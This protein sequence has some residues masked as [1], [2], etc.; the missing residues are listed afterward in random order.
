MKTLFF[1]SVTEISVDALKRMNIRCVFLDIDNT[2]KVYGSNSVSHEI[3]SWI[4]KLKRAEIKII[5]CSNNYE[6]NVAPFAKKI[7]CDYKSFCLKPSPYG[8]VRAIRKSG[9]KREHVLVIG[10]QVFTD[11]LGA[12]ICRLKTILVNPIDERSESKT[13]KLRRMLLKSATSTIK[14]RENPFLTE[15]E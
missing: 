5:L 7:G 12:K 8:Y 1:S 15:E 14:K 6:K 3:L 10:D 9:V 2:I 4:N 11:I 13:V